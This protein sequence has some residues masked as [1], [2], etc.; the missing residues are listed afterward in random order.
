MDSNARF[1]S[2]LGFIDLLF[3]ILLGF[4]FLFIVAFLLIKPEAKKKDFDRRAEFV[5]ILEWDHDAPDDL[6]LYVQDP[7][8]DKVSFR[9]PIVN[10]MH[11]DKDDLGKRNDTITNADGTTSTVQINREVVTI[12]GIMAGEYI[13]NAHYYSTRIYNGSQI[14][15]DQKKVNFTNKPKK[16]LTVKIELHKVTPYS[17]LWAGE[18]KFSHR[19]QEETFLRFRL[20]KD[21]NIIPPFTFEPKEFVTPIMGMGNYVVPAGV[22]SPYDAE[23]EEAGGY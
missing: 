21:G 14:D 13:V 1:K 23:S 2:S 10:F 19:G 5:I 3:N 12:R 17:I 15:P 7:T 18:K 4:A 9:L 6:D 11:L 20:D 16:D 22:P 8:N